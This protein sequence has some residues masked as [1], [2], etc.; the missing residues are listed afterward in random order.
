M[1]NKAKSMKGCKFES[2]HEGWKLMTALIAA[3]CLLLISAAVRSE[4]G[5]SMNLSDQQITRAVDHALLTDSALLNNMIDTMVNDGIVTLSG[6]ANNLMTKERASRIAQTIRGVRGVVNMI[7]LQTPSRSDEEIR[8][9][10][11]EALLYDAATDSYELK[12]EVKDGVVTLDGT[13]QSYREKQLAVYVAKSVKGVKEVNDNIVLDSKSERPDEQIVADVRSVI[14]NDVWLTNSFIATDVKDGVVTLTGTVGSAAQHNRASMLAWTAGV[15][16]VNAERLNV[17]PWA[18]SIDQRKKAVATDDR[19][20]E[21]AVH[22][23]FVYDPRV[24]SLNPSVDVDKGVVT[25]TGVVDSLKARRAAEQDARNTIGVWRVKNLLKVRPS[26]SIP[27]DILSRNVDSALQRDPFVDS[28]KIGVNAKNGAITLTGV[29]DSYYEKAQ[30]EDIAS[31]A[32]GVLNVKNNLTVSYPSLVYHDLSYEPYWIDTPFYSYWDDYR[33]LYSSYISD[34]EIQADIEDKMFWSPF[35]D[36][37]DITVKV[38]N[39]AATLTGKANSW[40]E[41]KK[42]TEHA[43]EGG[44]SQVYNNIAVSYHEFGTGN[45]TDIKNEISRAK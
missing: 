6:T 5:Y 28:Y 16:S 15:K 36:L 43:Y 13:V 44:A 14:D 4:P 24:Y 27:D 37:I 25:L 34:A 2:R 9:N 26:K 20:I 31:R 3:V 8:K 17:E 30:A 45:D 10:V 38:T 18:Q 19:Q 12:P 40:L 35:V 11:V 23:A 29:V 1:L 22:D 33:P 41:F 21:Q 42:A 32:E 7:A 39:G